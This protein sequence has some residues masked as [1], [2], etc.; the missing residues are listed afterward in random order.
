MNKISIIPIM[1][2]FNNNYV[3]PASV[4]IYSILENSSKDYMYEFYILHSDI[5]ESNKQ[6]L[7]ENIK[8]FSNANLTFINMEN[9][10]ADLFKNTSCKGHFSKEMYYK[11]LPAE[12]FPQYEK[13]IITDVDVVFKKDISQ[14][15]NDFNI[16]DDY[17]LSASLQ[18]Y[19][20]DLYKKAMQ[21]FS[22][23][24]KNED[25]NAI[26]FAGG[27]YI[28][29]LRKMREDKIVNKFISF[30]QKNSR[31]LTSPEQTTISLVCYPKIKEMSS[32]ALVSTCMYDYYNDKNFEKAMLQ[33][34]EEV[35]YALENPI[36]LHYAG[37]LKPWKN[38]SV[39]KASI[40]YEYLAKTNFYEEQIQKLTFKPEI[41]KKIFKIQNKKMKKKITCLINIENLP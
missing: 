13:M 38:P 18:I 5:S 4:A 7:V 29:N 22:K 8:I 19:P 39:T 23:I 41:S 11:F 10:F 27:F 36:Q 15:F 24:Y 35:I 37:S 25:L 20:K 26:F 34:K 12:I 14:M 16:N 9:K 6:K 3:I 28:F 40:W 21:K 2:C 32:N 1:T 33:S 31:W 30:A 17:Y